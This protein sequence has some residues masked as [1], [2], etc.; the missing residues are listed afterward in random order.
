MRYAEA[1]HYLR[2]YHLVKGLLAERPVAAFD[3][4]AFSVYDLPAFF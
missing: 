4:A 2:G 3:Q 1:P